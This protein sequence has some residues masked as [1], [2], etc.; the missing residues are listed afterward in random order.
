MHRDFDFMENARYLRGQEPIQM[1][2]NV[3]RDSNKNNDNNNNNNN[4]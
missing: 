1:T 4:V 2:P 3:H